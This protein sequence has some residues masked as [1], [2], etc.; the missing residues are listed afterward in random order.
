MDEIRQPLNYGS[1]SLCGPIPY[2]IPVT[3]IVSRTS[4]LGVRIN[5]FI[6]G[7]PAENPQQSNY[8]GMAV[9]VPD[10]KE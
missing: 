6:N 10:L 5:I 1:G 2:N 8:W 3:E 7:V 9:Y 4:V